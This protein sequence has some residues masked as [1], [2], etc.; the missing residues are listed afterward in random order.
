MSGSTVNNYPESV[1]W[2]GSGSQLN[3]LERMSKLTEAQP[4][5][6]LIRT[7]AIEQFRKL[8]A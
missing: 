1:W 4:T 5:S 8:I 7:G 3:D 2:S 6:L